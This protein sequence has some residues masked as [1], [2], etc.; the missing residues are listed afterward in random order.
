MAPYEIP[1]D[2]SVSHSSSDCGSPMRCACEVQTGA[3]N[4]ERVRI[5]IGRYKR[6]L[7]FTDHSKSGM[8]FPPIAVPVMNNTRA[9]GLY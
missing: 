9:V 4:L 7:T 2:C 8:A 3:L 6:R 5:A 1:R